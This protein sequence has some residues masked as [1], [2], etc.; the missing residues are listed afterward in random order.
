MITKTL[1]HNLIEKA[2]DRTCIVCGVYLANAEM[3]VNAHLRK[4]VRKKE[5]TAEQE[6]EF[7]MKIL[8]RKYTRK[9]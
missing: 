9:T 2:A 8:N 5:M 1:D 6:H 4:H 7:R 3:G